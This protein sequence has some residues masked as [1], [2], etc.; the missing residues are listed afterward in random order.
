MRMVSNI[1]LTVVVLFAG[2]AGF[3]ALPFF[4]FTIIL[5]GG[6]YLI[7]AAIHDARIKQDKE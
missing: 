5:I 1:L 2:I 3:I 6:G 4:I 7:Y